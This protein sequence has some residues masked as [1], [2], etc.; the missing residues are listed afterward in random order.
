M[1]EKVVLVVDDSSTMRQ[2]TQFALRRIQEIRC[3]EAPDGATALQVLEDQAIDLILL[4]INMPVMNGFGFLES[5]AKH[6]PDAPPI[7][8]IT[9]EGAEEDIARASEFGVVAYVTKPVQSAALAKT[10]QDV[11]EGRPLK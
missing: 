2:L 4:D 5:L 10:V 7:I 11:L 1:S 8:I 6:K 3:V 9:T